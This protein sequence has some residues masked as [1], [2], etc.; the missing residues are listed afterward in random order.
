MLRLPVLVL[1]AAVLAASPAYA[2]TQTL[3]QSGPWVLYG[4]TSNS[5]YALCGM[6]VSDTAGN[7]TVHIK[8]F[9]GDDHLTIQMFKSTWQVPNGTR[10]AVTMQ[11]DR[12]PMWSA[13]AYGESDHVEFTIPYSGLDNFAREFRFSEAMRIAFP[14]GNE[15]PWIT[16]LAGTNAMLDQFIGCMRAVRNAHPGGPTQPYSGPPST[17][18][19]PFGG[20]PTQPG[21]TQPGPTQPGASQPGPQAGEPTQPGGGAGPGTGEPPKSFGESGAPPSG[22]PSFGGMPYRGNGEAPP[23]PQPPAPPPPSGNSDSDNGRI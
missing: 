20:G 19:Q 16:S 9:A 17:P 8:Y 12:N 18:S 2:D 23:A 1:S 3:F 4:G 13:R 11:M 10:L 21:P 14:D 15:A 22:G 6:R 7:R 5:G